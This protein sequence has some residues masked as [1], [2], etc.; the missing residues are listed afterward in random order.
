MRRHRSLVCA[1]FCAV[2]LLAV[3]SGFAHDFDRHND[4]PLRYL[5]YPFHAL[6]VFAEYTVTRP[7]HWLVSQPT[8]AEIFGHQGQPDDDYWTWRVTP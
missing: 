8:W 7:I 6:G 5:S 4:H 1:I 3:P 2:L